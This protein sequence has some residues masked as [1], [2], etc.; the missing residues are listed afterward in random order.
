M[1][2][3]QLDFTIEELFT[4]VKVNSG[5]YSQS[6]KDTVTSST[7]SGVDMFILSTGVTGWA[8]VES[9]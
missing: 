8:V 1:M 2:D 7:S 3:L 4:E 6:C 9:G 5:R